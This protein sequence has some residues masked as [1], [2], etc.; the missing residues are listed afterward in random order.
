MDEEMVVIM[1]D[2]VE[3]VRDIEEYVGRFGMFVLFR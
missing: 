2:D 3:F 1:E